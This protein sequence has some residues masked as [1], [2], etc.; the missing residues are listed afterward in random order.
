LGVSA[1]LESEGNL[2]SLIKP[3]L[4]FFIIELYFYD[5]EYAK[6]LIFYDMSR[7]LKG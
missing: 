2:P 6:I 1:T 4:T 7:I 5:K 3:I